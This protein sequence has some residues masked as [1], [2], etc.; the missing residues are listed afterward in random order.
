MP[1]STLTCGPSS[2]AIR[3][4]WSQLALW[5]SSRAASS[6]SPL[7]DQTT[8]CEQRLSYSSSPGAGIWQDRCNSAGHSSPGGRVWAAS[9]PW[10]FPLF[11]EGS[12]PG[13]SRGNHREEPI[14]PLH[15][16]Q[17]TELH[18]GWAL[19]S[20]WSESLGISRQEETFRIGQCEAQKGCD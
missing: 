2:K 17:G 18:P 9:S 7:S 20:S 12:R 15:W 6:L 1:G 14:F 13:T 16:V 8:T 4:G 19:R 5:P 11:P 10:I 3:Q